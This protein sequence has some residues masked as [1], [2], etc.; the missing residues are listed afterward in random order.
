MM[1][2]VTPETD[3]LIDRLVNAI[4]AIYDWKLIPD[5]VEIPVLKSVIRMALEFLPPTYLGYLQSAADGIDPTEAAELKAWLL[6]LMNKFG[7]YIPSIF[8][9]TVAG[10]IVD[11]LVKGN[12]IVVA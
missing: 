12:N 11:A 9:E 2:D 4:H 1:A 3:K 5:A 6:D 10:L 8:R 7:S